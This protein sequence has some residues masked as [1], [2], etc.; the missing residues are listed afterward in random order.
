MKKKKPWQ[1]NQLLQLV[2]PPLHPAGTTIFSKAVVVPGQAIVPPCA[3]PE[4]I[5][6]NVSRKVRV[7]EQPGAYQTLAGLPRW[8]VQGWRPSQP[9][10]APPTSH[11]TCH[12]FFLRPLQGITIPAGCFA[13]SLWP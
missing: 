12:P 8:P 1:P 5:E 13:H 2:P 6:F 11:R 4:T 9:A 10:A 7:C 3:I